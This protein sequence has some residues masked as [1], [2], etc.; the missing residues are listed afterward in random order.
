MSYFAKPKFI[1]YDEWFDENFETKKLDNKN[2]KLKNISNIHE[3]FYKKSNYKVGASENNM[4]LNFKINK[5][6]II[7]KNYFENTSEN[8]TSISKKQFRFFEKLTKSKLKFNIS[9]NLIFSLSILA[10]IIISGFLI[11]FISQSKKN[12]INMSNRFFSLEK[13][14]KF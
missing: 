13:I 4:Q 2:K 12:E 11:I 1:V 6:E 7:T 14:F 3:F 9:K 5:K 8:S 10:F